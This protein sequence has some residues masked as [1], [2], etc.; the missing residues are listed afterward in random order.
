MAQPVIVDANRLVEK[1]VASFAGIVYLTV[2]R[3]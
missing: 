2:G 1:S 3:A